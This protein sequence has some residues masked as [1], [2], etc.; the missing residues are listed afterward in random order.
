ML[1]AIGL[2]VWEL[3]SREFGKP[4]AKGRSGFQFSVAVFRFV[5]AGGSV[6]LDKP[7][8]YFSPVLALDR[9]TRRRTKSPTGTRAGGLQ[10]CRDPSLGVARFAN[11]STASG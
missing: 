7:A 3:K 6:D 2:E 8:E 1:I 9:S 10:S 11:D 5:V 4:G